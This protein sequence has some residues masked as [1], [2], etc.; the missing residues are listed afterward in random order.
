MLYRNSPDIAEIRP[1]IIW[2]GIHCTPLLIRWFL[3]L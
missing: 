2:F 3:W 1:E